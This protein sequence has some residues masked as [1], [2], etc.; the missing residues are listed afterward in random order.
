MLMPFTLTSLGDGAVVWAKAGAAMTMVAKARIVMSVLIFQILVK[1]RYRSQNS[2][3]RRA[4][5]SGACEAVLM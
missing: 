2:H 5:D 1:A 3:R 4:G